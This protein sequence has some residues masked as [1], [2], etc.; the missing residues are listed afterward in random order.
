MPDMSRHTAYMQTLNQAMSHGLVP[1]CAGLGHGGSAANVHKRAE[2]MRMMHPT[3]RTSLTGS[4][5]AAAA[6]D[7][8]GR[9]TTQGIRGPV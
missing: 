4:K 5:P 9:V 1:S 7:L 3:G 2:E 8:D 6:D